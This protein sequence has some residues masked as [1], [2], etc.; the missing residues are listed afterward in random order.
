MYTQ[1]ATDTYGSQIN[2]TPLFLYSKYA[3]IP[4]TL[5]AVKFVYS[6]AVPQ[7]STLI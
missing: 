2:K 6:V 4:R 5:H 1:A 7:Q 3:Y